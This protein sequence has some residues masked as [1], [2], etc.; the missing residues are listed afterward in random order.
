M[1]H[2]PAARPSRRTFALGAAALLGAAA[3]PA[4]PR[5]ARADAGPGGWTTQPIPG[6]QPD[7]AI[8]AVA[9]PAPPGS[10]AAAGP[11]N[12]DARVDPR[13]DVRHLTAT[14]P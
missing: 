12:P 1:D 6:A 8:N 3:V 11:G 9:A 14:P 5:A 4:L 7:T 10:P 2:D 13:R